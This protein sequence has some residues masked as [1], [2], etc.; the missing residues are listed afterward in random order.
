MV[1]SL[2]WSYGILYYQSIY[3]QWI[4]IELAVVGVATAASLLLIFMGRNDFHNAIIRKGQI[5]K[6]AELAE[7]LQWQTLTTK[8]K[9][10]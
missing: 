9:V 7:K 8:Q 3:V 10:V 4:N 5:L 6:G 2:L 1:G